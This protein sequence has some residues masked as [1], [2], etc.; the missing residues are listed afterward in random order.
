MKART[1]AN[2]SIQRAY[3]PKDEAAS[4][5]ASTEGIFIT[6]SIEAKQNRDVMTADIP[7]AFVQTDIEKED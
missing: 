3:I 4:P 2:G 7:N 1:Y 6:S 5:I